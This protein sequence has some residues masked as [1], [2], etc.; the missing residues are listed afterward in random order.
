MP[1]SSSKKVAK[2]SGYTPELVEKLLKAQKSH[3]VKGDWRDN[4]QIADLEVYVCEVVWSATCKDL[5]GDPIP[6]LI[7][8]LAVPR[9]MQGLI[10]KLQSIHGRNVASVPITVRDHFLV[11]NKSRFEEIGLKISCKFSGTVIIV[12]SPPFVQGGGN[13]FWSKCESG[14]GKIKK[15]YRGGNKKGWKRYF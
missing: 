2:T 5:A 12:S 11:A 6:P 9:G 7:F 13:W 8:K 1:S 14:G 3:P 15:V 10:K 4:R